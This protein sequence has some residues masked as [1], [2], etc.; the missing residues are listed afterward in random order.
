[1]MRVALIW[2]RILDRME[3]GERQ[4]CWRIRRK[5]MGNWRCSGMANS[6]LSVGL[7]FCV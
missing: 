2:R 4:Y 3:R 1:M 5:T 7:L 6:L